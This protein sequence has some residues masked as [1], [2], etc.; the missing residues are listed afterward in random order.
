MI[1]RCSCQPIVSMLSI[2]LGAFNRLKLLGSV[3]ILQP[4][5]LQTVQQHVSYEFIRTRSTCDYI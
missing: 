5:V 1:D 4:K 2:E 3:T